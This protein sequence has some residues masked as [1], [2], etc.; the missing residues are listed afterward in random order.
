MLPKVISFDVGQEEKLPSSTSSFF[1]EAQ[2]QDI[3]KAFINEYFQIYDSGSRQNLEQ[4][5]HANAFFSQCAFYPPQ[6]NS[7]SGKSLNTYIQESRNLFKVSDYPRRKKQLRMGKESI[8]QYLVQ[9]PKTQHDLS[10]FTV[11]LI[12]FTP[13]LLNLTVCG[14][15]R[16]PNASDIETTWP[17]RY[18][19]R[20]F[21]IVPFGQ[22]FCIVNDLFAITNASDA[23]IATAFKKDAG[24]TISLQSLQAAAVPAATGPPALDN[25]VRQQ[26]VEALAARTGM[27]FNYS[28]QCLDASQWNFEQAVWTFEEHKKKGGIPP[29]AF[30]V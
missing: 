22:G 21:L 1:C 14:I 24:S 5:Y 17:V 20:T 15:F 8:V 13:E 3:V 23:Q 4:A 27:N 7:G 30:A 28:T 12:K 10:S 11:D 25:A 26:M 18:F 16:E 2:G 9:L 29:E 19:S 6:N